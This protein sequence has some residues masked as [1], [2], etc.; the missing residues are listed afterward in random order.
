MTDY[1]KQYFVVY[2][3]QTYNENEY[4]C[5]TVSRRIYAAAVC[6]SNTIL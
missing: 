6:C 3:K 4:I 2:K 1:E 5:I